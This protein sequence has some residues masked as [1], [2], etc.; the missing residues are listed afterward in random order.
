LQAFMDAGVTTPAVHVFWPETAWRTM[1]DV[2]P[3]R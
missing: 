3:K 1:R 2:A